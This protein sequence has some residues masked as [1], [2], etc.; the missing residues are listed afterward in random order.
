MTTNERPG[1]YSSI[2]VE[3]SLSGRSGG[4]TVGLTAVSGTGTKGAVSRITSLGEA[5]SAFGADCAMTKLIRILLLNGAA[6]IYAVPAAVDATP[7][8]ADYEAAFAAL[9]AVESVD[10][11][12]CDSAD[13]DVIDDMR[14][15]IAGGTENC[16]YR[17][18]IAE[19]GGTV[20]Q[21]AAAALALNSERMALAYPALTG[22]NAQSGS[23]A[24]ALAG[25]LASGGDPALPINGAE[26][27]GLD[28]FDRVF[29]DAEINTLVRGGVTPVEIKQGKVCAVRGVTTRSTTGG[30]A[31]ATW[32]ELTTIMIVD[33][34]VP[35]VRSALRLMFPRVKNTAQTRGAIRTQVIIELE[36][37]LKQEIIDSYGDVTVLPDEDDPSVCVVSFEFTVAHGLNRI[38]L[39]AHISV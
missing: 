17:I 32:R 4:R 31:D 8:G 37:K 33:D 19:T 35:A 24:A 29:T 6:V 20:S 12:L 30:E 3:S 36:K 1:V 38:C 34:V 23:V 27:L 10:I 25:V 2:V 28:G 7:S 5:A 9:M 16:K 15:A 18:G 13:G 39:T 21:A 26:M 11:M 14:L 22:D